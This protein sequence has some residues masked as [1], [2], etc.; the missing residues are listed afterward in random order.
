M[1]Q[2]DQLELSMTLTDQSELGMRLTDQSELSSRL[3]DQS[4]LSSRLTDQ[5]QTPDPAHCGRGEHGERDGW[6]QASPG[7]AGAG[8]AS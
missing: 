6:S 5:S 1:K 7:A 8:A 2:D 3:T 4:E